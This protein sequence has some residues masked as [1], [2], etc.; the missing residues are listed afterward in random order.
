MILNDLGVRLVMPLGE[1]TEDH[2]IALFSK[3]FDAP[4]LIEY[5]CVEVGAMAFNCPHGTKHISHDHVI[6]EVVD[7]SGH[8]VS[9]GEIGNV[10]LTPLLH[11]SMPLIRYQLGDRAILQKT[12]CPCGRF[13]GLE[14]ISQISGRA[15]DRIIDRFGKSWHAPL[16]HRSFQAILQPA[17]YRE[18]QAI[19]SRA[20]Q[21]HLLIVPGVEFR[22]Q[23]ADRL[24]SSIASKMQQGVD[25]TWELRKTI[26]REKSGK[27]RLFKSVIGDK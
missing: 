13:P 14:V 18:F 1:G 5:G 17:A 16:I 12:D 19:Q 11:R 26:E 27:L 8:P 22:E 10:V 7:D 15:F 25:V 4:V 2:Q 9:E 6:F 24:A 3:V 20:G 23:D 21:L